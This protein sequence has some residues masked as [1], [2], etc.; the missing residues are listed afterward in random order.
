MRRLGRSTTALA[1]ASAL[2]TLW[3]PAASASP[4]QQFVQDGTGL[5]IDC[6]STTYTITAGSI[7]IV[8]HEGTTASGNTNF[9]A[10]VTTQHVVMVD[11]AGNVYSL[12]GTEWFGGTEN[13]QQ[14]TFVATSTGQLQVVAMGSGTVDNVNVV[15]HIT[16]VNG[17]VKE[18][19]FGTCVLP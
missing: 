18:F 2:F 15:E 10:T 9:T 1:S 16:L 14:G 12:R 6:G 8:S 7:S 13:A 4:A 5:V 11:A 17:N 3:M 19:D